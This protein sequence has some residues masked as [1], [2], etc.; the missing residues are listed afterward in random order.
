MVAS[1]KCTVQHTYFDH[2]QLPHISFA[3]CPMAGAAEAESYVGARR[4]PGSLFGS[5]NGMALNPDYE[6]TNLFEPS[7]PY[8]ITVIKA[9]RTLYMRVVSK[10]EIFNWNLA[11][12][13]KLQESRI[14]FRLMRQRASLFRNIT[15]SELADDH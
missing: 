15:I 8:Q 3:A 14:G 2:M 7:V 5:F 13:P 9:D 11:D 6:K 4:Y 12:I 10:D 1:E